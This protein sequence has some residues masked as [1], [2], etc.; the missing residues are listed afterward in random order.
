MEFTEP[1]SHHRVVGLHHPGCR[2]PR[3][4]R[5]EAFGS[6]RITRPYAVPVAA[7][8]RKLPPA[9]RPV[10]DDLAPAATSVSSNPEQSVGV[11][12]T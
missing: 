1:T 3:F 4:R 10:Q 7:L 5:A 12:L 9:V 2:S 6:R 11:A 8:L